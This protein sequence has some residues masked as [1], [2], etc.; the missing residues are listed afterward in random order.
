[1]C[2]VPAI[3]ISV[4]LHPA[5]QAVHELGNIALGFF[6]LSWA[7]AL[8]HKRQAVQSSSWPVL[9]GQ[10]RLGKLY[11][12]LCTHSSLANSIHG[13]LGLSFYLTLTQLTLGY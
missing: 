10:F 5:V 2:C 9:W 4:E 13:M 11:S 3:S 1:M 7:T 12:L 6:C 8:R